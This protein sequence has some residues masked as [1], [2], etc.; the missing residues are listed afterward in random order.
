MYISDNIQEQEQNK[1]LTKPASS[2]IGG[3]RQSAL[4]QQL[5]SAALSRNVAYIETKQSDEDDDDITISDL[6][7]LQR[8]KAK[9]EKKS[10]TVKVDSPWSLSLV[11][12]QA[13]SFTEATAIKAAV[14][15]RAKTPN[16]TNPWSIIRNVKY[17][18]M[19]SILLANCVMAIYRHELNTQKSLKSANAATIAVIL[20]SDYNHIA[21]ALL[22]D[23]LVI[24]TSGL[25]NAFE[26]LFTSYPDVIGIWDQYSLIREK[27]RD[28]AVNATWPTAS[29]TGYCI[30]YNMANKCNDVNC[31]YRN[32]CWFCFSTNHPACKC[33]NNPVRFKDKYPTKRG[34]YDRGR[35]NYGNFNP[36]VYQDYSQASTQPSNPPPNQ[37][38]NA[39]NSSSSQPP[40]AKSNSARFNKNRQ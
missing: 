29:L 23:I 33:P 11:Y 35:G 5:V 22:E 9:K 17:L 16:A 39:P 10:S 14:K 31:K 28:Q 32:E 18:T 2:Y 19:D 8:N 4:S 38:P 1:R 37:P 24:P 26:A 30:K 3:A 25:Y 34:G 15:R 20:E 13:G 36:R 6:V 27:L 40:P 12:L 21:I 7:R